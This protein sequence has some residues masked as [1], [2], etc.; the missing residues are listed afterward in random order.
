MIIEVNN[1]VKNNYRRLADKVL[2][3]HNIVHPKK[4]Q[5]RPPRRGRGGKGWAERFAEEKERLSQ[6]RPYFRQ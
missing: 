3:L 1:Q 2:D 6:N 4:K 5:G